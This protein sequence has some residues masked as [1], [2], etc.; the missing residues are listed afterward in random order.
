MF[1]HKN[2]FGRASGLFLT[3][4]C[5]VTRN[6]LNAVSQL[7]RQCLLR[8]RQL[9][10]PRRGPSGAWHPRGHL[11]RGALYRL[12]GMSALP[13]SW[14]CLPRIGAAGLAEPWAGHC[15]VCVA[16]ERGTRLLTRLQQGV[17]G[18]LGGGGAGCSAAVAWELPTA[19][20][21]SRLHPT[22]TLAAGRSLGP[23]A[24]GAPLSL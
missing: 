6:P 23:L 8:L 9:L 10:R 17:P 7:Q 16:A 4:D 3:S 20:L 13:A 15:S 19:T 24:L 2:V 12:P 21:R 18:W 14:P 1:F 22:R 11:D 5:P